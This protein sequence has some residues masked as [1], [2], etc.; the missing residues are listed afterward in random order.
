MARKGFRGSVLRDVWQVVPWVLLFVIVAQKKG[1][2]P[3]SACRGG[4]GAYLYLWEP[5]GVPG[6]GCCRGVNVGMGL[7]HFVFFLHCDFFAFFVEELVFE[8]GKLLVGNDGDAK[9]ILELPFSL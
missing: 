6:I 8:K 5:A 3:F 4:D 2:L 1:K 7:Y 9:A